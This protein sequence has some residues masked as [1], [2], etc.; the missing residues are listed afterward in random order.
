MS[1]LAG[2]RFMRARSVCKCRAQ[3][4]SLNRA[5][6]AAITVGGTRA[7]MAAPHLLQ[8]LYAAI[9]APT[10]RALRGDAGRTRRLAAHLG[11][12]AHAVRFWLHG[13]A[14]MPDSSLVKL[15]D[16][17]LQDDIARARGDRRKGVRDTEL[18]SARGRA[19]RLDG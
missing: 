12:E 18:S 11:V 14:N 4:E 3:I 15:M 13:R 7:D 1:G 16:L 6:R 5:H 8:T 10:D 9:G 17:V 2:I 19:A